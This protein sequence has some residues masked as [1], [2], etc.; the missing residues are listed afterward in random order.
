[1]NLDTD[2]SKPIELFCNDFGCD[3]GAVRDDTAGGWIV[4]VQ[5]KHGT[6]FATTFAISDYR[7]MDIERRFKVKE[8]LYESLKKSYLEGVKMND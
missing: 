7:L 5:D 1:M 2:I 8:T 6:K 4:R 3:W